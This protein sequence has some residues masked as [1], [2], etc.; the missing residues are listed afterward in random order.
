MAL[1]Q[2]ARFE[3]LNKENYD[4]WRMF[5]EALLVKNDM[6]QYVN[7]T[8]VKPEV[9]AGNAASTEAARKWEQNDAKARS[10]I[11]LSISST[12]LKQIKGCGTS[13]EVWLRLKDT[14]QSKGPARKAALLR[15]LTTLKMHGNCDARAHLNQFFDVVDKINEIGVEIDSDLLSTML[16]ISLP[17]EFENFRCAIEARDSLPPLDVLRVKITEEADARKSIAGGDASN[18]MYAKKSFQR[19]RRKPKDATGDSNTGGFRYKCHKCHAV[20]HKAIDCKKQKKDSPS[21]QKVSQP[22]ENKTDATMLTSEAYLT[23]TAKTGKWC[24]DSGATS[25]FCLETHKF[26]AN[27]SIE[28]ERLNLASKN[29]IQIKGKGTARLHANVHGESRVIRLE[30]TRLVPDLRVNLLSVSKITDHG[31]KVVFNKNQG[32][33]LDQ[34]GDVKLVANKTNNLYIV[35][36]PVN[37]TAVAEEGRTSSTVQST[38]D[39]HRRFGHLNARDLQQAIRQG[40]VKGASPENLSSDDCSVCLEGKMTRAPFPVRSDRSTGILDL[41]HTDLCGPMRTTSMGGAKYLLQF[42]DDSSRWGQVYFLKRKSDVFQALQDFVVMMENQ[43]GKKVKVLQSDNGKEFVNAAIDDFLKKR[44][45]L[46]RL[47]VPYCPEQNGVAE[48]RNRTLVEMARCLL[49]QS[50]LPPRFWAEA[51]NTA[52]HIRNRCPTKSLDGKTPFEAISGKVPDVSYFKEF[53][54]RTLILNNGPGTGKFDSRGIIGFLVGYSDTAK[55][56]RVWI[57]EEAKPSSYH[58]T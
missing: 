26:D 29:S 9:M 12:E 37:E 46:R 51:V 8:C 33:V 1:A 24:L 20:G 5:M 35:E 34:N 19:P 25:H 18:A 38:V 13:R 10:D 28:D 43:T 36:E 4:T 30:D 2:V 45:I 31:Y 39:W 54:Q 49:L 53:G 11:V 21:A 6:W 17:S 57:P 55:G 14:Y 42:I 58:G 40:R 32:L 48:R 16:L 3:S 23:G 7:G 47:T 52:N 41:V 56:Y 44:G 27:M 50:N 15:Q 22:T